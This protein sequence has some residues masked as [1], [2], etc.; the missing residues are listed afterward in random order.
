[1]AT[2]HHRHLRVATT[3]S[4]SAHHEPWFGIGEA[5]TGVAR[6]IGVLV[7]S[8]AAATGGLFV[9]GRAGS[10]ALA[11]RLQ[12]AAAA[13]ARHLCAPN[14]RAVT[15]PAAAYAGGWRTLP[16]T[17]GPTGTRTRVAQMAYI[18][19]LQ[20]A[21]LRGIMGVSDVECDRLLSDREQ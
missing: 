19:G 2:S 3:G 7:V 1:M 18:D 9:A 6:R 14:P 8:F 20:S 12:T 13:T 11:S 15:D 4:R 10:D 21:G 5:A 16:A 17:E